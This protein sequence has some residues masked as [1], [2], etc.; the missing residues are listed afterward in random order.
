MN[1]RTLLSLTLAGLC[2]VALGLGAA[3]LTS[4]T[5]TGATGFGNGDGTIGNGDDEQTDSEPDATERDRGE[6]VDEMEEEE[7]CIAGYNVTELTM[8]LF[9]FAFVVSMVVFIQQGSL[10][11]AMVT[12][13][14]L[15]ISLWFV[16]IFV[17]TFMGC[18]A[19]G[20][21]MAAENVDRMPLG[22]VT[23]G[24]NG[25]NGD[26]ESAPLSVRF[27]MLGLLA[28]IITSLLL[29]GLY[30]QRR[31][32]DSVPD[33]PEIERSV[34]DPE[35]LG[36]VAGSTADNLEDEADFENAIYQAWKEMTDILD[37]DSPETSTPREFADEARAAGLA[38]TDVTELTALF[39]SVRYGTV[40][41]TPEQEQRAIDTLRRIETTYEEGVETTG[42]G[43]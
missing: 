10:I 16:S 36:A 8:F 43:Q 35:E 18:A 3:T 5:D 4:T 25:E 15:G 32:A 42:E 6:A 22:D 13:P 14:I 28:V 9:L 34:P 41:P 31:D 1:R 39:E 30:I 17:F 26:E 7:A 33:D 40:D 19:P 24:E 2:I 23:E 29:V 11:P 20:A 38:E 21:E 12:F 27:G 37:V